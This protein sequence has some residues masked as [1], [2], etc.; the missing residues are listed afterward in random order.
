M[1]LDR[2]TI[3]IVDHQGLSAVVHATRSEGQWIAREVIVEEVEE[4]AS[5]VAY[6]AHEI[7]N[8]ICEL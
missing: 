4:N 1:D 6:L 2:I 7:A 5:N 8:K 3:A